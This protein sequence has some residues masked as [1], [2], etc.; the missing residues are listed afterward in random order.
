MWRRWAKRLRT[1]HH[2]DTCWWSRLQG[3]AGYQG[4][5]GRQHPHN[6]HQEVGHLC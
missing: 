4:D 1:E 5:P 3:L 2:S 6:P